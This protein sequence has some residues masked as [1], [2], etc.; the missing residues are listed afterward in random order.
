[1]QFKFYRLSLSF[2]LIKEIEVMLTIKAIGILSFVGYVRHIMNYRNSLQFNMTDI[3]TILMWKETNL[4]CFQIIFFSS[5]PNRERNF[6]FRHCVQ[7]GS[8]AHPTS[9]L[10][11]SFPSDKAAGT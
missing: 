3:R 1:M 11:S 4:A 8:E 2:L 6:F 9:Y 10:M 7:T 5:I